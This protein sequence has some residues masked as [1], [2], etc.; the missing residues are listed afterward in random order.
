MLPG[1]AFGREVAPPGVR[2]DVGFEALKLH[3][4]RGVTRLRVRSVR[5]KRVSRYL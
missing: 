3:S 1:V 4:D 2:P 5:I